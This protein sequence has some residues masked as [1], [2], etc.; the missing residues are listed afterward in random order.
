M[1]SVRQ[2]RH[3]PPQQTTSGPAYSPTR[4]HA[5]DHRE[6]SLLNLQHA[7]G[8]QA[9]LQLMRTMSAGGKSGASRLSA[10]SLVH[11]VLRSPGEPLGAATRAFMEPRFGHDFGKVRVH[12]DS[13]AAASAKQIHA[14]AYAMGSHVVL[15]EQYRPGSAQGDRLL[16]HELVHTVQQ[17]EGNSSA[18]VAEGTENAEG[19][20]EQGADRV[21]RSEPVPAVSQVQPHIAM[22]PE[23]GYEFPRVTEPPSASADVLRFSATGVV[24]DDNTLSAWAMEQFRQG[25]NV[26]WMVRNIQASHEFAGSQA[27]RDSAL[28]GLAFIL[29]ALQ[30]RIAAEQQ[31]AQEEA[32]RAREAARQ[33]YIERGNRV[34]PPGA[35]LLMPE[36]LRNIRASRG[37]SYVYP[38]ICAGSAAGDYEILAIDDF[39]VVF[40][41]LKLFYYAMGLD[42]FHRNIGLM[43]LVSSEVWEGSKGILY[44]GAWAA[45]KAGQI[46]RMLPLS[47]AANVA[48]RVLEKAGTEGLRELDRM[49]AIRQGYIPH[50]QTTLEKMEE[51]VYYLDPGGLTSHGEIPAGPEEGGPARPAP[52]PEEGVSARPAGETAPQTVEEVVVHETASRV[53]SELKLGDE[54]HGIAAYGKG[55]GA[56]FTFCSGI[57]TPVT[58]KVGKVLNALPRNYNPQIVRGLRYLYLRIRGVENELARGRI[59]EEQ[60]GNFSREIARSLAQYAKED[61]NIQKLLQ[62]PE[63]LDYVPPDPATEKASSMNPYTARPKGGTPA[64][65]HD[66]EAIVERGIQIRNALSGE[67]EHHIFPQELRGWFE[68]QGIEI[69]RYVVK[70]TVGEHQAIHK[71]WNNEWL[72][73]QAKYANATEQ[74]MFEQAGRMM[75]KYGLNRLPLKDYRK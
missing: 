8:N 1:Q 71:F 31:R 49:E 58:E 63:R 12:S 64:S 38:E 65:V 36:D 2:T 50:E 45:Q 42:D 28:E 41:K 25:R 16:A 29:P 51:S 39:N 34:A 44:L 18:D 52:G 14:R 32:K 68:A 70:M 47:P 75:D 17:T 61:P 30:E 22:S 55:K 54:T 59:T 21:L 46:G 66:A 3:R 15:G 35:Q 6:N 13:L 67:P 9:V 27:A 74:Q 48:F 43:G 40:R 33:E 5:A 37:C 72:E 24:V 11:E 53:G 20:A 62:E 57:C 7:L 56:R 23:P 60:A 10:P 19:E 69:D 73:F 26:Q 4:R